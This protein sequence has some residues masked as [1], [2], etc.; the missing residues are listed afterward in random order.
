MAYPPMNR[1]AVA[2]REE[3]GETF[4]R[5]HAVSPT[6]V[7]LEPGARRVGVPAPPVEAGALTAAG[8]GRECFAVIAA[9]A[10]PVVPTARLA[11]L[12]VDG[13]AQ[14]AVRPAR[15]AD[16]DSFLHEPVVERS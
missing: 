5:S 1:P 10:R 3:G 12:L 7:L 6:V 8:G 15:G 14:P 11:V 16:S 2:H 9:M 13:T 4:T